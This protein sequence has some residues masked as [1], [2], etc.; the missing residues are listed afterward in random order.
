MYKFKTILSLNIKLLFNI[1]LFIIYS[2]LYYCNI[3]IYINFS[4][5]KCHDFSIILYSKINNVI[6]IGNNDE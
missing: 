1:L 2:I 6:K 3:F 4:V 5:Y